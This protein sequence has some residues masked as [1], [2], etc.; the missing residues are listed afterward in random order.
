MTTM[1]ETLANKEDNDTSCL[2]LVDEEGPYIPLDGL[3]DF[4][5]TP[6]RPGDVDD[7]VDIFN[8]PEV[9]KWAVFR[10][11]PY[12]PASAHTDFFTHIPTHRAYL[13]QL[14]S[15]LPYPPP[16]L[17]PDT[18][19]KFIFGAVRQHS[20][21]RLVGVVSLG[22][23]SHQPGN[24]EV[25]YQL[26]PDFHRRGI[27]KGMIVSAVKFASWLGVK[28]VLA[29]CE[30][31]NP[32]SSGALRSAGFKQ[33]MEVDIPLPEHLGGKV[34]PVLFFEHVVE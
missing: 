33:F 25:S 3:P 18:K 10:D 6:W 24:W 29:F 9:E 31:A 27:G 7:V 30:K 26:N 32:A 16:S 22:E 21:G 13:T 5:L 19:R 15:S 4:R 20:T 12:T 1:S 28:R 11:I 8:R 34:R 17:P 2:V 14:I 23:S